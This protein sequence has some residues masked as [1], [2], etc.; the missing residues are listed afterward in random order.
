MQW[1]YILLPVSW[2]SPWSFVICYCDLLV[3]LVVKNQSASAGDIRDTASIP[4]WEDPLEEGMATHSGILAWRIL[5]RAAWQ[6]M[7][8]QR[9]GHDWSDWARIGFWK[10]CFFPKCILCFTLCSQMASYLVHRS[11]LMASI[12]ISGVWLLEFKPWSTTHY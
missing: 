3:A 5:D 7:G 8:S 12:K 1:N 9:D 6:S 2:V 10:V 4:G 11:L